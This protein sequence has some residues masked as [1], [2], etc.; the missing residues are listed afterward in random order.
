MLK[1]IQQIYRKTQLNLGIKKFIKTKFLYK[2]YRLSNKQN[3]QM[4]INYFDGF[5]GQNTDYEK[6]NLGLGLIHYAFIKNLKAKK[7]LC[8]GS[9][10]GFIPAMCALACKE[11]NYGK[12]YF[13]DA[14]Y[15]QD[16]LE[17][18]SGVGFWKKINPEKHFSFLE[19]NNWIT[20]HVE[21]TQSFVKKNRYKKYDYIYIDGDHSYKGVKSDFKLTWPLLNKS[22]YM[23]FHDIKP[24]SNWRGRKFGVYKFWN[25]CKS[26]FFSIELNKDSGLGILQKRK[27]NN[28]K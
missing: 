21:T 20:T 16:K 9:Q 14:G 19:L 24:G 27:L 18:W 25:E 10:Q 4:I 3:S 26:E 11:N 2:L 8:I 22:G 12:V 6:G 13:V 7:I 15:D 23:S 5:L 28:L 1:N 17:S